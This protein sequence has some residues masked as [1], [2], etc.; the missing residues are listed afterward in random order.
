MNDFV[1]ARIFFQV[2]SNKTLA[3][4]SAKKKSKFLKW[5]NLNRKE[6][7]LEEDNQTLAN[8][9]APIS[10]SNIG[11]KLLKQMGYKPGSGL[12]KEESGRAEPVGLEIRRSR[13]GIG[14]KSQLREKRRRKD[15]EDEMRWRNE[16]VLIE[17]FGVRQKSQWQSRRVVVNYEKA[18]ATLDQL[19]NKEIVVAKKSEDEEDVEEEEE[20]E[21]ITEEVHCVTCYPRLCL[22]FG[23]ILRVYLSACLN[24]CSYL[25]YISVLVQN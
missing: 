6:R 15:M 13:G 11:F 17:D 14:R 20:E 24:I 8:I 4:Q 25:N 5:Q 22:L 19:E 23:K 7:Q 10:E 1:V 18:K 9:K 12:G 3:V 16:K 2:S 21:V